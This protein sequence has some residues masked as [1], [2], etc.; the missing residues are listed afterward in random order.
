MY[1][2]LDCS[3]SQTGL[4]LPGLSDIGKRAHA[5]H[6]P[7]ELRCARARASSALG[8]FRMADTPTRMDRCGHRP[9]WV[10]DGNVRNP[11][12]KLNVLLTYLCGGAAAPVLPVIIVTSSALYRTFEARGSYSTVTNGGWQ[13]RP[14]HILISEFDGSWCD[15]VPQSLIQI[16]QI[17]A[18][19]GLAFATT[20]I[21]RPGNNVS[22]VAHASQIAQQTIESESKPAMRDAAIPAQICIP[23]QIDRHA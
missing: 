18:L 6:H 10:L 17:C 9:L 11:S 3:A 7:R 16:W 14:Y 21:A 15:E 1:V 13:S 8:S 5:L 23:T 12:V 22:D 20:V 4:K 2:D 19:P